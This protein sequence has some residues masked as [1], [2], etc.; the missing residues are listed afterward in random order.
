MIFCEVQA[1]NGSSILNPC[2]VRGVHALTGFSTFSG[3][4][5]TSSLPKN[6]HMFIPKLWRRPASC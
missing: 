6:I 5:A 1:K 4:T 2:P 3:A